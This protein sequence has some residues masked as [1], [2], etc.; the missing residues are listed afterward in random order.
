MEKRRQ[1][2]LQMPQMIQTWK[3]VCI[4][5]LGMSTV[6]NTGYREVTDVDGRNGR[7]K[8]FVL[9]ASGISGLRWL[10]L[11]VEIVHGTHS[12]V[13]GVKSP[14]AMDLYITCTDVCMM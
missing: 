13:T 3:E 7:N 10:A 8:S 5:G 6:T 9:A 14:F 1:A 4:S 2:M 11:L 12:M